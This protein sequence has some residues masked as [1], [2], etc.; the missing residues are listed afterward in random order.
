MNCFWFI[1]LASLKRFVV[2]LCHFWWTKLSV[3]MCLGHV[4]TKIIGIFISRSL[5]VLFSF[6]S[7]Y[8]KEPWSIK[9]PFGNEKIKF[10]GNYQIFNKI[11]FCLLNWIIKI[12]LKSTDI[13]N[14]YFIDHM[15]FF[16]HGFSMYSVWRIIF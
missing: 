16:L 2:D 14:L 11:Y 8:S 9:Y 7:E 10:L 1:A 3:I 12:Y 15:T 13:R 5:F 6:H 4:K